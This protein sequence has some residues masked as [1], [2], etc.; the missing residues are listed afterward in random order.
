MKTPFYGLQISKVE[1]ARQLPPLNPDS[2]FVVWFGESL[3]QLTSAK[4]QKLMR[5]A[6]KKCGQDI[7][8]K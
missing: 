7:S 2:L 4:I 3:R 6:S 5:K 8:G 1:N